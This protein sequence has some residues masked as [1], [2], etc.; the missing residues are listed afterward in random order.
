MDK[1]H[2][3]SG[4]LPYPLEIS[5]TSIEVDGKPLVIYL[6]LSGPDANLLGPGGLSGMRCISTIAY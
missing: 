5:S 1:D 3:E 2:L 6:Q 4:H